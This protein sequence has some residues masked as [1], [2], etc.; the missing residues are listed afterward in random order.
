MRNIVRATGLAVAVGAGLSACYPE[1]ASENTD[2]AS[3]TTVYDTLMAFDSVVTFYVPD[4]VVHLGTPDDISHADDSLILARTAANMTARGY[5]QVFDSTTADLT[6]NPAVTVTGDYDYSAV[7]WCAV[8]GWA[9]LWLCPSWIPDYPVDVIGYSYSSGTLFIP[10]ADL[11][12]GVPPAA[13]PPVVW[14]AGLNGVA[15]GS[16][17]AVIT[18]AIE[19]GIDQAF[20]QSPYIYRTNP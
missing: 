14:V 7:D 13:S 2:Y 16:S 5:T 18:Q 20:V 19:D 10:M 12:G 8:W 15:S 3:I 1:R 6:L 17:A 9:Y 4:S 11:T